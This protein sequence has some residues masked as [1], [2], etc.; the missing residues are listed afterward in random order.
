MGCNQ[1]G[2]K[3]FL[4]AVSGKRL[5]REPVKMLP[6]SGVRKEDLFKM[7]N[8]KLL[9]LIA[10]ISILAIAGPSQ[11]P[12]PATNAGHTT[13]K[14][15][16][17]LP[18]SELKEGMRGTARTVFRGSEAEE[19]D[20]EILGI[21]PGAIGPKQDLI[22][23]RLSGGSADRTSVFAGMSGSPVYINGKLA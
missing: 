5:L 8:P 14:S 22:V 9:A 11:S 3:G 10:L 12:A 2:R 20:V 13:A 21:I 19:F 23:G 4:R 16:N 15:S 7:P 1:V 6:Y 18:L 17:F